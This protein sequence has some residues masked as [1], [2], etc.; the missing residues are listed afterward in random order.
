MDEVKIKIDSKSSD[1]SDDIVRIEETWT[2]ENQLYLKNIMN[3]CLELSDRHAI[4]SYYN[5][6]KYIL[7][8]VP[9]I[10]LPL[11]V[12]NM[13]IFL[14]IDY[15][16]TVCM[17][18]VSI[19]NGLNVLLNYSKNSEVH[20]QHAGLYA[21]LAAE[22]STILIRSKQFRQPFDIT[23]QKITG[24]KRSIDGTAPPV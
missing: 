18:M 15:V 22:I 13:S 14:T 5:K 7:F 11:I 19:L 3:N 9:T 16:T 6:K 4:A 12:A 24:R 20:L 21:D 23:L 17:T 1:T 2:S 8:S 10:I